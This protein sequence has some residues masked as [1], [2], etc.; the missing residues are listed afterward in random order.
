[1]SYRV[2][3]ANRRFSA[4]LV[5][6]LL[7]KVGDILT[8]VAL[9]LLIYSEAQSVSAMAFMMVTFWLP[10]LL[11]S[12]ILGLLVDR[13]NRKRVMVLM[14]LVRGLLVLAIPFSSVLMLFAICFLLACTNQLFN[15]AKMGLTVQLVA[16]ENLVSANSLVQGLD[17]FMNIGGP[18]LAGL[19]IALTGL[20]W[21]FYIDTITYALSGVLLACV[22]LP[23]LAARTASTERFWE[24]TRSNFRE[25]LSFIRT[26]A[27]LLFSMTLFLF[28]MTFAMPMNV[29]FYPLFQGEMQASSWQ[30][31]VALSLFS[32][33][34]L[35]G[36]LVS[37]LFNKRFNRV[38]LI[39]I[40]LFLMGVASA[41]LAKS[42]NIYLALLFYAGG[43]FFNGFVNPLNA[44]LR[45]E[46]I[47]DHLMGRVS[48]LYFSTV[49]S[50]SMVMMVMTGLFAEQAGVRNVYL[51]ASIGYALTGLL[52]FFSPWFR[53]TRS[54]YE[55]PPT[56]KS[57]GEVTL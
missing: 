46:N 49:N 18:A 33:C 2:V 1:M 22:S 26:S 11:L 9:P 42:A 36:T 38:H 50:L 37:P 52:G 53:R 5:A 28:V 15:L 7:S 29:L 3:L 12:P 4:V 14:D 31:G 13:W 51:I 21:P 8:S 27:P 23:Q 35:T 20:H 45:Q 56:P 48:G 47:P 57:T 6:Q 40:G 39:L 41:C 55:H 30:I 34:S 44:S 24:K 16:K 10:N 19:V 54:I 25:G 17:Q 32:I 43:A